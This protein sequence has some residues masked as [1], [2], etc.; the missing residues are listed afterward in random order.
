[1]SIYGEGMK[2]CVRIA[3]FVLVIVGMTSA[4]AAQLSSTSSPH[5]EAR[6]LS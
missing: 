6:W 5:D 4:L 3:A 2:R 1:M